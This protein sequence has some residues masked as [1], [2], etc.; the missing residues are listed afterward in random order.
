MTER[1]VLVRLDRDGKPPQVVDEGVVAILV[2]LDAREARIG[3]CGGTRRFGGAG[4]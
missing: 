4:G 3:E 2:M 1:K